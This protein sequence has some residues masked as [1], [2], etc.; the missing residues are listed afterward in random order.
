MKTYRQFSIR[1]GLLLVFVA[2]F[3]FAALSTGG[4]VESLFL[5][6]ALAIVVAFVI[7]V[8]VARGA[9]R[10]CSIGF[11][12]PVLFYVLSLYVSGE[13]ELD[14]YDGKLPTTSLIKPL[15]ETFV[16]YEYVDNSNGEVV[17]GP[18]PTKALGLGGGV[19]FKE[20]RSQTKFMMLAHAMLA[21]ICGY[22][23]AKFASF[24]HE[25]QSPGMTIG[26]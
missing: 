8:F 23:G 17:R 4:L 16:K 25:K 6:F 21:L 2:A 20:T 14:P 19:K 10:S 12:I 7:T 11:V 26:E 15:S 3:A 22:A 24:V 18:H 9:L 5:L 13:S 1:E